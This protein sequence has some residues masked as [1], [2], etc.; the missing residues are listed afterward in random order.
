MSEISP[1]CPPVGR[2]NGVF[3]KRELI[4]NMGAK[5]GVKMTWPK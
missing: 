3:I 4:G 2:Q 1:L 5:Y